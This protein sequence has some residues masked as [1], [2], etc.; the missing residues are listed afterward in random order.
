[1]PA[2]FTGGREYMERRYTCLAVHLRQRASRASGGCSSNFH[3]AV[4][5]VRG[6]TRTSA[7]SCDRCTL[8]STSQRKPLWRWTAPKVALGCRTSDELGVFWSLCTAWTQGEG[9]FFSPC[10]HIR[11]LS[12]LAGAWGPSL[13]CFGAGVPNLLLQG[14]YGN[15]R[16]L[17]LQNGEDI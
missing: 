12:V 7:V 13:A 9:R 3:I 17:H 5:F 10:K 14:T 16:V 11:G 15:C 8:C 4:G 2:L 1:M 6:P